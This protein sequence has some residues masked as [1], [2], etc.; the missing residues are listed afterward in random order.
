MTSNPPIKHH[1]IAQFLL[2]AWGDES[3]KLWRFT[4]PW[5]DKVAAKYVAPAEVGYEEYLYTIPGEPPER[6]Q[7]IEQHLMSRL[8]DLAATA[9]QMLL[10]DRIDELG[11]RYRS[12]WSRFMM[13]LWFRTPDGIRGL[14][15][16]T[17][18]LLKL[19][20]AQLAAAYEKRRQPD[21]P[22]DWSSAIAQMGPDLADRA[23]MHIL[24]RQIDDPKNGQ[25]LNNMH[26][27]VRELD[28]GRDLMISDAVLSQT[29][30]IFGANGYLSMPI[31]PHTVFF[32][33]TSRDRV[34][35]FMGLSSR[36][37]VS[38]IN[39]AVVRRARVFIG[40][41]SRAEQRF[42]EKN[43]RREDVAGM[44]RQLAQRYEAAAA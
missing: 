15:D 6:A 16:A 9:H 40:A 12:A 4:N 13:S 21:F 1:F 34:N 37:I 25:R 26:W 31:G 33:A 32:A 11:P 3:G 43:L 27:R 38:L 7:R 29:A 30:A 5:A 2:G 22:E 35:A 20:D 23:A 14:K 24:T 39:H 18:A 19:D 8:D 44:S 10:A 42:V 36:T 28:A 17:A 41:T